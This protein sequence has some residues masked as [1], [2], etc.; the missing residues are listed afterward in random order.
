MT[1][2]KREAP[3]VLIAGLHKSGTTGVYNTVRSTVS[4]KD[5]YAFLYEPKTPEPF[6]ALGRYAPYR[7][8]VAKLLV[9]QLEWCAPRYSEFDRRIMTARDPRDIV[10]SRLLFRPMFGMTSYHIDVRTLDPFV[11]ALKEKEADPGCRSIKSLHELADKLGISNAGWPGLLEQMR[12]QIRLIDDK[13]FF[14]LRYEDFV[15]GRLDQASEYLGVSLAESQTTDDGWKGYISRSKKYG[16]WKQWFLDEDVEYFGD[17]FADYMER[18]GY[19]DWERV[20][21]PRVD[22][23]TSSDYI[24]GDVAGRIVERQNRQRDKWTVD[25]V[26]TR[27]ELHQIESM[28][29]DGRS[30]WAYRVALV[31]EQSPLFGPDRELASR[32]AKH[33]AELGHA[34]AMALVAGFLR[35]RGEDDRDAVREARFWQREH[36]VLTGRQRTT[37]TRGG[38]ESRSAGGDVVAELRRTKRALRRVR[39]STRYRLG[40]TVAE[41]VADPRHRALPAVAEIGRLARRGLTKRWR[42][43]RTNS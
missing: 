22:P 14:V 37:S 32:W 13:D 26:Q 10:V 31:Y 23:A 19:S 42:A 29:A 11:E 20:E 16:E 3:D 30:V 21:E 24:A 28:A 38:S 5:G 4:D 18:F 39:S 1:L 6:L 17:M 12:E 9:H 8:V 33:G 7:P 41:A 15:D 40:S 25:S 43:R 36:D 27:E 35:D 34:P 2:A